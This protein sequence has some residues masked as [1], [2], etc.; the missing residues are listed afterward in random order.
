M[1]AMNIPY[2][3]PRIIQIGLVT[4]INQRANIKRKKSPILI[5]LRGISS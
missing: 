1:T 3:E 4:E 2:K 5:S